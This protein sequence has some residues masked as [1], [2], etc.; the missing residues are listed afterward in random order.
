M[1]GR[2][3]EMMTAVWLLL[4]PF[5]FRAQD[6]PWILWGDVLT[7]GVIAV[8]SGLSYTRSLRHAHWLILL[9]AIGLVV[10][11]RLAASPPA[12][13][14]DQNHIFVGFFLMMIAIIPNQA[15]EPPLCWQPGSSSPG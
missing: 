3:V 11:G 9:V 8:L 4:S 15:S 5:I 2:V 10:A 7:A 6:N 13:A 1:W 14:A 12:T